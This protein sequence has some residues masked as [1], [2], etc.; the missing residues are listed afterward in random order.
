M[1][2][3]MEI[4]LWAVPLTVQHCVKLSSVIELV[5][6]RAARQNTQMLLAL[7]C[8]EAAASQAEL[9]QPALP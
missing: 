2:E 3:F 4:S 7:R 1:I 5:R 9:I 8:Y 6:E